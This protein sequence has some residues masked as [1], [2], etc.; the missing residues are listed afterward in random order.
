MSIQDCEAP[1]GLGTDDT[2]TTAV[3]PSSHT[4][5]SSLAIYSLDQIID[6]PLVCAIQLLDKLYTW[7]Q[8]LKFDTRPSWTIAWTKGKHYIMI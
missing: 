6:E 7:L 5:Y 2:R 3:L 1:C 8:M 4:S